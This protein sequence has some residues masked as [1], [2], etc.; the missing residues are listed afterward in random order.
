MGGNNMSDTEEKDKDKIDKKLVKW[1]PTKWDVYTQ[2][3]GA[4]ISY[5]TKEEIDKKYKVT[6]DEA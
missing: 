3:Q 4:D 1:H 6:K 2:F 5:M